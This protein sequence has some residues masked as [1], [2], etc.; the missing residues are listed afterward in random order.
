MLVGIRANTILYNQQYLV[1]PNS[2][3]FALDPPTAT[4]DQLNSS[5]L[6]KRNIPTLTSE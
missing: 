4:L 1:R 5:M 6:M 3:G 2:Q